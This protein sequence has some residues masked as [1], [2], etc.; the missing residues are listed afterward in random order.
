MLFPILLAGKPLLLFTWR[1]A[2]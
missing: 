2:S 1:E